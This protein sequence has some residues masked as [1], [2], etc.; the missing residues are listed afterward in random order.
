MR[1]ALFA[2]GAPLIFLSGGFFRRTP[3]K[4]LLFSCG[5]TPLIFRARRAG[6]ARVEVYDET[7]TQRQYS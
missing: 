7:R 5:G 4:R 6:G 1:G 3:K 2:E